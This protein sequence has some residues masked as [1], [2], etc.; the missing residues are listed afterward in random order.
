MSIASREILENLHGQVAA[1]M[2]S[3]LRRAKRKGES[4][5]ASYLNVIRAFLNDNKI[6]AGV[7]Y[8]TTSDLEKAMRDMADLPFP[9]EGSEH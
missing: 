5:Q 8:T 7:S 1:A 9:G 4:I 6:T 3:E 2:L